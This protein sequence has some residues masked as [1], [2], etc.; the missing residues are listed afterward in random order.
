MSLHS[1]RTRRPTALCM[2][3]FVAALSPASALAKETWQR[4]VP[5]EHVVPEL[6]R[7]VIVSSDAPLSDALA[8]GAA[9]ALRQRYGFA[10]GVPVADEGLRSDIVDA[11]IVR[12]SDTPGLEE[13]KA[14]AQ[15]NHAQAVLVGTAEG[16]ETGFE[17]Y[18]EER[19]ET[20]VKDGVKYEDRWVVECAR[21]DVEA[22][23]RLTL[24]SGIDGAVIASSQSTRTASDK[25]CDER[26]DD[27]LKL[28]NEAE[29][30]GSL[31]TSVGAG[32]TAD[33]APTWRSFKVAM[34]SDRA[35]REVERAAG[36]GDWTE[37]V[38]LAN[39]VLA[40]DPFNAVSVY[41]VGLALELN[42]RASE[43]AT[44][45]GYASR[46]REDRVY[47]KARAGARER[48]TQLESLLGYSGNKPK[49][50]DAAGVS[51]LL[52]T[53][54][55]ASAV[56]LAGDPVEVK[57]TENKRAPVYASPDG[58]GAVLVALPGGTTVRSLKTQGDMIQ[59]QLPDGRTGWMAAKLIR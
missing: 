14:Y 30:L 53:A 7:V 22:S 19:K 39:A 11:V 57:G 51:T 44:L 33:W 27:P 1:R 31:V 49:S 13:I 29:L 26:G 38:A 28:A 6:A 35:S 2:F 43:A 54:T 42:G 4:V 41:Y 55:A 18:K 52:A 32:F 59:V 10:E 12:G 48:A 50:W 45:Y 15:A 16:R 56:P 5:P 34:P 8:K 58:G 24:Y 36:D 23:W 40:D 21:R 9:G 20:R 47:D 46:L 3:T 25:D 17:P 37:A